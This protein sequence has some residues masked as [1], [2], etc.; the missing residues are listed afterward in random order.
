M[1]LL[2]SIAYFP[3]ISYF[4][5]IA[6]GFAFSGPDR[7]VEPSVVYIEAHENYQKQTWRNRFRF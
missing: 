5:L 6:K 7:D 4:A 2:L 1:A 3:P